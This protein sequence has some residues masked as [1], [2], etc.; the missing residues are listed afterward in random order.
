M[1]SVEF[2]SPL[3]LG[4]VPFLALV[5][6]LMCSLNSF[7]QDDESDG[8]Q[9]NTQIWLDFYPHFFIT[10]KVQFYGDM[11]F[12]SIVNEHDWKR[13]H[14]R[15][16]V[17]YHYTD[18]IQFRGGIGMFYV[19]SKT[20][21]NSFEFSPWQGAQARW[22]RFSKLYFN[23]FIRFEERSIWEFDEAESYSF[24]LRFRYK[25][26]GT[27]LFCKPCGDQYWSLPFFGEQFFPI[28]SEAD[29]IYK[30][31]TRLGIGVSYK[32]SKNW[33]YDLTYVWQNGRT[34]PNEDFAVLDN[35]FRLEVRRR[36]SKATK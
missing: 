14:I 8:T 3:K 33:Q 28:A 20:L 16:S 25:L 10:E 32:Q 5:M 34:S 11:G 35:I 36:I 18:Y 31:R 13:L 26:T 19:A 12:R 15:P 2:S 7:S 27:I 17:R 29:E 1:K 6:F 22:P 9:S 21:T 24:E 4:L 30:N 23:H